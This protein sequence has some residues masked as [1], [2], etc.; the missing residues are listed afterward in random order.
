MGETGAQCGVASAN[1]TRI[2]EVE[3]RGFNRN[4]NP[5]RPEKR[6][7]Q[8]DGTDRCGV[9]AGSDL[10]G[11]TDQEGSA[12]T[13]VMGRL[14]GAGCVPGIVRG[15]DPAVVGDIGDD[16]VGGE[17]APV[18]RLEEFT[19]G[20]IEPFHHGPVA[21]HMKRRGKR[22][23]MVEQTVGRR[24][25]IV[26]HQGC[27]PDHP[28]LMGTGGFI[29]ELMDGLEGFPPDAQAF[30][31]VAAAGDFLATGHAMGEAAVA[32]MALPPFARLEA[33]IAGGVELSGKRGKRGHALVHP[34]PAIPEGG[35]LVSRGAVEPGWQGR[36]VA[37][38]PVLMR[39]TTGQ[40]GGEAGTTQTGRDI[41][42]GESEGL[43]REP[44]DVRG[45]DV[46]MSH[47]PVIRPGMVI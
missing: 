22:T 38:D 6:G 17:P 16:G 19:D 35:G 46:G 9:G 2:R 5:R 23:V 37:G 44:V 25:R 41:A 18:E 20:F 45:A 33:A 32:E 1:R 11:P 29:D 40:D 3:T 7:E 24:V 47:E 4:L 42:A 8:V 28:R 43:P 13:A 26:R 31:A 36:I 30:I 14:L 21:G 12:E 10:A 39:I 34:I 27:I 15:L